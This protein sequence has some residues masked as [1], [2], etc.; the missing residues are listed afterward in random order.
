VTRLTRAGHRAAIETLAAEDADLA[1]IV[2]R[3]GPPTFRTRPA[4]FPTLLY[5]ILEQ[6][7]SLASAKATYDKVLALVDDLTPP[8]YLALG[9]DTLRAAGLSRQKLRYTR[10]VAEA[11]EAGALPIDRL[12]R[13]TDDEVRTLLTAITGVGRW[14]ADCYLMLAL[15]RPDLWPVGDL[16]LVKAVQAVKGLPE[17]PEVDRLEA[18]GER[19]RPY[20]SVATQLYWHHYLNA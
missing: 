13:K 17:R 7:V 14:T 4:G 20:R 8:A 16:A 18:L 12:Q 6:Q 19:Y 1:A 15:K 10:L 5:I 3:H 9:D 11:I 2:A